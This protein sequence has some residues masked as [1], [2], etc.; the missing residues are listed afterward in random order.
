LNSEEA[1]VG[2]LP[3]TLLSASC[4][5]YEFLNLAVTLRMA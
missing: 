1:Q 4:N 2:L 5:R 3:E